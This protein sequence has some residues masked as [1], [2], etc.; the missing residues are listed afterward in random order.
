V[1][2]VGANVG[3]VAWFVEREVDSAILDTIR[4]SDDV[5][6]GTMRTSVDSASIWG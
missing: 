1:P 4:V 3:L 2:E 6:L 5:G